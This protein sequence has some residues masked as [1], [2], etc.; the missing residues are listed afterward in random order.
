MEKNTHRSYLY[1]KELEN[2]VLRKSSH[3]YI[4]IS[5][6]KLLKPQRKLLKIRLKWFY[7]Y[8]LNTQAQNEVE[9]ALIYQFTKSLLNYIIY[10]AGDEFLCYFSFF[11]YICWLMKKIP[12][13]TIKCVWLWQSITITIFIKHLLCARFY[14]MCFPCIHSFNLVND[15]IR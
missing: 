14:P 13:I 7:G 2:S 5:L 3:P 10:N 15:P 8:C 12:P 11:L 4:E 9:N 1:S 6:M